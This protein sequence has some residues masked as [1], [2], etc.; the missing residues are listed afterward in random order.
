MINNAGTKIID[1]KKQ[2]VIPIKKAKPIFATEGMLEV[3]RDAKP[4]IVVTAEIR[5]AFPVVEMIL[6][7]A[8]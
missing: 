2:Y 1:E 3:K 5:I 8:A 4:T 7:N 6:F